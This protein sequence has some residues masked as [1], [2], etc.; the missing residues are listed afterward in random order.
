MV[1]VETR[2][3][4]LLGYPELWGGPERI[5]CGGQG[6][7][8]GAGATGGAREVQIEAGASSGSASPELFIEKKDDGVNRSHD[9]K[10]SSSTYSAGHRS[11]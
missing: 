10:Y 3:A 7:G 1:R 11:R 9:D 4:V 6:L 2:T 5:K 8:A